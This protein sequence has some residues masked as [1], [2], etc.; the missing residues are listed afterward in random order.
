MNFSSSKGH[1]RKRKKIKA[2]DEG[3]KN[4]APIE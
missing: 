1:N 3:S 4:E 2:R